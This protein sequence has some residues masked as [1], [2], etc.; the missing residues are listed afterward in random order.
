MPGYQAKDH[1]ILSNVTAGDQAVFSF[2]NSGIRMVT[3][4]PLIT[5]ICDDR[6]CN[7]G[8]DD[9]HVISS[10]TLQFQVEKGLVLSTLSAA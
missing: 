4:G 9:F 5:T 7:A 8:G 10:V 6:I 2:S 3:P 1:D